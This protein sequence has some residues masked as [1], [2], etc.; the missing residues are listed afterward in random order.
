MRKK[1]LLVITDGIGYSPKTTYN[2][3]YHAKKPTY[4]IFNGVHL[5]AKRGLT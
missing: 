2:A 1:T 3:F 5:W 4:D